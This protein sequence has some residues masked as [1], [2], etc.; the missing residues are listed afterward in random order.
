VGDAD[1]VGNIHGRL[2]AFDL[3][4][5]LV[6]SRRDLA[7]AAN[8]LIVELGGSPLSE[9]DIGH[10]VGDGAALLV[11]RALRA[12]G[13]ADRSDA[14]PRFLEI[15]D[16][17]LLEHTRAYDGISDAIRAAREVAHVAVLTNKPAR[18]TQRVLEGVGLGSCFD[19]VIAGDGPYPRKP[20]PTGLHALMLHAGATRAST[21]LVGDSAIDYETARRADVRCCLATYG[22][23]YAKFPLDRSIENV[24]NVASPRELTAIVERFKAA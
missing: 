24:W 9:D 20:D 7:N 13:I 14:L 15:Y 10:M 17:R 1:L 5:T 19:E 3:D 8:Q 2:I 4:G 6:D 21:L 18:A 11:R 16:F 12:S 23:G 22:F